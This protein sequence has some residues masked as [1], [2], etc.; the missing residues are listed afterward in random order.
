[1][2]SLTLSPVFLAHLLCSTC[3]SSTPPSQYGTAGDNHPVHHNAY[4]PVQH[5]TS[6]DDHP[7]QDSTNHPVQHIHNTTLI[8]T[9]HPVHSNTTCQG[10]EFSCVSSNQCIPY[11]WSCD[12]EEDCPDGSD[13]SPS[14]CSQRLCSPDEWSCHSDDDDGHD[15]DG[16]DDDDDG[17]Q[18]IP[19]SWVCDSHDDCQDGSDESVCTTTCL[20]EEF[21]CANGLCVQPG[22]KC[23]G[24]DDCGDGS[25]EEE[26]AAI[27]CARG[28]VLCSAGRCIK[29]KH[30]C[31]GDAGEH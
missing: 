16:H 10:G 19:L 24:E 26:C 11:R 27:V 4:Q 21:T 23:D 7:V 30:V 31:D 6:V 20:A 17:V 1:M 9:G 12:R 15:D 5:N 28:E 2:N 22:W 13:E 8:N 14:V 18:C 29:N 25:D 3:Q